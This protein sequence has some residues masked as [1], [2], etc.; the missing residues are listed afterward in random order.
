MIPQVVAEDLKR[1]EGWV[2]HAVLCEP[3]VFVSSVLVSWATFV[4]GPS[5]GE[6]VGP[7]GVQTAAVGRAGYAVVSGNGRPGP[8]VRGLGDKAAIP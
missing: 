2:P 3:A 4:H 1:D 5:G 6:L 7:S 8:A